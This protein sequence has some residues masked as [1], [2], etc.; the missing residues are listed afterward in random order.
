MIE[1]SQVADATRTLAES[2]PGLMI[3]ES[4]VR[5]YPSRQ[6]L[7]VTTGSQ[8]EPMRRC[9]ALP[10]RTT[11]TSVW[12]PAIEWSSRRGRS[13]GMTRRFDRV[14]NHLARRGADV[15]TA[16]ERHVHVSG[17]GSEEELK[18]MLSLVRP[19]YFVPVHGEFRQRSPVRRASPT[20]LRRARRT[21]RRWLIE[22]GDVLRFDGISG[23]VVGRVPTG[24][25]ADRP[26]GSGEVADEVLRDRRHLA[27][28]GLIVPVLAINKQTGASRV[29]PDIITR[30]LV[31]GPDADELLRE[32]TRI[33][34]DV[35][36]ETSAEERTDCGAWSRSESARSCAD[37]FVSV[38]DG[39][40]WCCRSSWR[41]RPWLLVR[42]SH[43][44][45]ASSSVWSCSRSRSSG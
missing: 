16:A 30:G 19:R 5:G 14:V 31:L 38:P 28:D 22:N 27:E 41:S 36:G 39:G 21:A 1:H 4:D 20:D 23:G 2:P 7:C 37:S 18:L 12:S 10:W 25:R 34:A 8:G 44:A 6:V 24:P 3:R 45:S 17:H 29:S 43:A 35:L 9:R 26:A 11:G 40:R 15:V 13:R 42:L 32:A 33:I